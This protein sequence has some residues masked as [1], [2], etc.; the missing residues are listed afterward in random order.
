MQDLP[1]FRRKLAHRLRACA[2]RRRTACAGH[3]T[4]EDIKAIALFDL[5]ARDAERLPQPVIDELGRLRGDATFARRF[6][7]VWDTLADV[8]GVL[9]VP[10]G[11]IELVRWMIDQARHDADQNPDAWRGLADPTASEPSGAHEPPSPM[12][13]RGNAVMA[14]MGGLVAAL[15]GLVLA[16]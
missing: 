1:F 7:Q 13:H 12:P 6:D 5:L 10:S 11:A 15:A 2:L 3:P 9:L 14:I 8:L 4:G 16:V